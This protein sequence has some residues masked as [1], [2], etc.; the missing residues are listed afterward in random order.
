MEKDKT[1]S[2]SKALLFRVT[3]AQKVE[4][5]RRQGNKLFQIFLSGQ[6]EKAVAHRYFSISST[7]R[8]KSEGLLTMSTWSTSTTIIGEAL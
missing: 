6:A 5:L 1:P 4:A 2:E 8:S 7:S 3:V